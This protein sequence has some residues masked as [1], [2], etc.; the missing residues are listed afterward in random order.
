MKIKRTLTET[1]DIPDDLTIEEAAQLLQNPPPEAVDVDDDG[2]VDESDNDADGGDDDQ[3][4]D[5]A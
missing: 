5:S 4:D 1:L 3:E 2:D